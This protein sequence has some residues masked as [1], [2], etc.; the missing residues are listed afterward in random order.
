[1]SES[2]LGVHGHADEI[3]RALQQVPEGAELVK[4]DNTGNLG[5]MVWHDD[6]SK[7]EQIGYV[8]LTEGTYHE[9]DVEAT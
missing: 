7:F 4:L 1:M 3:I 8:D 5:V 2:K 9:W 6:T